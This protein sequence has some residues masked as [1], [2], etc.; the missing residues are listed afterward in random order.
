[1][2]MPGTRSAIGPEVY[3]DTGVASTK[4]PASAALAAEAMPEGADIGVGGF[5][6]RVVE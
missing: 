2:D 5:R 4:L 3:H 6:I 1:M